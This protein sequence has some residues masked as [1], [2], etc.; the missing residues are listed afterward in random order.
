MYQD[1]VISK[2][3]SECSSWVAK[4]KKSNPNYG[5]QEGFSSMYKKESMNQSTY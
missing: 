4:L 3:I 5:A 1:T 2:A